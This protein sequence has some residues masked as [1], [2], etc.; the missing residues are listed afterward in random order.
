MLLVTD[1]AEL[2]G[3]DPQVLLDWLLAARL[4]LI[5]D[6]AVEGVDTPQASRA[7]M[8]SCCSN[9]SRESLANFSACTSAGSLGCALNLCCPL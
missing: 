1:A 2:A 6:A 4:K 5:G 7:A 3:R 8:K 9:F